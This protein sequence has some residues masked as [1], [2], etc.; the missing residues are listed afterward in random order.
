MST[1]DHLVR[2][3]EQRRRHRDAEG[4]GGL[5][6]DDKLILGRQLHR[7]LSRFGAA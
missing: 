3:G 1:I 5:E 2:A 6:I 7:K 4:V